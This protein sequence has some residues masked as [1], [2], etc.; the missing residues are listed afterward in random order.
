MRLENDELGKSTQYSKG[1]VFIDA[2][3]QD[4]TST[5]NSSMVRVVGG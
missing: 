4:A 2:T 3:F 1:F 5:S